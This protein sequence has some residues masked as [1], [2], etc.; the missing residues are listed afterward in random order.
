VV[1]DGRVAED[2]KLTTGTWVSV[3]TLRVKWCPRWRRWRRT[4]SS[5]ATTAPRSARWSSRRRRP[6]ELP[7]DE[8]RAASPRR[9][10]R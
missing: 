7:P 5:P 8:L 9:C 2:F 4:W 6:R 3:G 10:A 1:F